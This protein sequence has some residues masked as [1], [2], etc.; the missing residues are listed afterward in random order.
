MEQYITIM[1][2][3]QFRTFNVLVIFAV[4]PLIMANIL[5][6]PFYLAELLFS[7]SFMFFMLAGVHAFS[8]IVQIHYCHPRA[9]DNL[10]KAV[11]TL[12]DIEAEADSDG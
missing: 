2:Q 4:L 5:C 6:P 10:Y 3:R 11:A 12:D 8:I 9:N 1:L 7:L